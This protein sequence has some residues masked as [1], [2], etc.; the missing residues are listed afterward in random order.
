MEA[1]TTSLNLNPY[2]LRNPYLSLHYY[3]TKLKGLSLFRK[4]SEFLETVE[5]S[6]LGLVRPNIWRISC[7]GLRT[8]V[9][10]IGIGDKYYRVC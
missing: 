8:W 1:V 6:S 10:P 7:G 3:L 5:K 2:G 4:G 9:I